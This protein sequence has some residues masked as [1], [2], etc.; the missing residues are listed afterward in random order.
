[1]AQ[2]MASG[3]IHVLLASLG[4]DREQ[5]IHQLHGTYRCGVLLVQFDRIHEVSSRVRPTSC[6]HHLH[7]AHAI[8]R[9]V[10]VGLQK[11]VEVAK[12]VQ[13]AFALAAHAKIEN[14]HSA[15][16]S[17]LPQVALMICAAAVV[18]LHVDRGFIGLDVG[19]GKQLAPHRPG[20][21]HQHLADG[22]HPAA[23][24]GPA[25]VDARVAKQGHA[26][27][28]K[29][30]VVT[31][32]VHHRVDDHSIRHQ[33]LVDDPGGQRR[34]H[35]ALLGTGFAGPFLALGHLYEIPRRLDIQHFASFVADHF[36]FGAAVAAYTLFRR[37]G[38][39]TLYT[40]QVGRECLAAGVLAFLLCFRNRRSLT[41]TLGSHF[42]VADPGFLFQQLQLQIT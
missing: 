42:L 28:I 3:M 11:S 33:A 22:H 10:G 18:H 20:Y 40:R 38:D 14:R 31:V 21:R 37:A 12:E 24:R 23:H 16:R 4:V 1:M 30:A 25:N 41:L 35:H 7:S 39:Y 2:S 19:A 17:I 36:G 26:L 9:S 15:W 5:L 6:M 32:L 13:R 34:G 29:G 27:P 8:V